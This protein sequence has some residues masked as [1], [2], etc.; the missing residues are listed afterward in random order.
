MTYD[1]W[2]SHNA[3]DARFDPADLDVDDS[4]D[5]EFDEEVTQQLEA[6]TVEQLQEELAELR[7]RITIARVML[8]PV[9]SAAE[10]GH[11]MPWVTL[12]S[13]VTQALA[14]LGCACC[15]RKFSQEDASQLECVRRTGVHAGH[16][17]QGRA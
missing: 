13:R 14:Q 15:G 12:D 4:V 2:K 9:L 10:R 7:K 16:C 1:A 8:L 6:P 5:V 11:G 3:Q 17:S